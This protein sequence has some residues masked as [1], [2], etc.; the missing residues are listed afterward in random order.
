MASSP[1]RLPH[2]LDGVALFHDV[3]APMALVAGW[4][5]VFENGGAAGG[6]G[7]GLIQFS[8]NV[9]EKIAALSR[10]LRDGSYAPGPLRQVDIPKTNGGKRRLT[11]PPIV[12]RVAQS[13]A[14]QVLSPLLDREFEDASFGYRAG[15]SVADAVRRVE[16]LRRAG[17]VWTVD[18]DIDDFFDTIPIDRLVGR[19][20]RSVSEGPLVD[21]IA[22]WLEHGASMGRGIAQGSPLSPLLAN[23][24][25]DDLDEEFSGSGL[26]IV[27]YADDFLILAKSKPA[28]EAALTKAER[29][30]ATHGL[31]LDREKTRLRGY[32]DS[33]K[34]LGTTFVRGWA[35]R[36]EAEESGETPLEKLLRQVADAD[37]RESAALRVADDEAERARIGGFDRGL[38]ALH[39]GEAGRRLTLRNQSFAVHEAA[40]RLPPGRDA[41]LIAIHPSRID[42]IEIGPRTDVDLEAIRHALAFAI[43]LAFVN[44]HGE[45]L[46]QLATVLTPR[47]GRHMAQARAAIDPVARLDLARRIVE[48]RI[49]NQRALLRRL[50]H[51]R[52]VL[53]VDETAAKLGRILRKTASA[54]GVDG[55]MG[56]E[57]E[58][59]A[60]YWRAWGS[61]LLNGFSLGSR[62]RRKDADPINIA[63]DVLAGTLAR[64]IG[65]VL[66][67]VGLHPGFGVLHTSSDGRDA[68]VYDL[69]EEFRAGL[70][71]SVV[72]TAV[73]GARLS[74]NDFD[75]MPDGRYHLNRQGYAALIRAYEERAEHPITQPAS[76]RRMSWRRLMIEQAEAYVAHVEGRKPYQPFVLDH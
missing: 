38:R 45:T 32:D 27:R 76:G 70:V 28:A 72:L 43:P 53:G 60:L 24:Y 15:R 13:A 50:N 66:L 52:S 34:F 9:G 44:G 4:Q 31:K 1:K 21:L 58:A 8:I 55:L 12:D 46:G 19:L 49:A 41:E 48:G 5:R 57:G 17:F 59:T 64:D 35:M 39:V 23:L 54:T 10:S 69:M 56:I 2:P 26:R 20:A 6:D 7:V 11:I 74:L 22:R 65:A 42:R 51:R 14:A 18:A 40:D 37:A 47:A 71:E 3:T 67:R 63:L 33:L 36:L 29:L 61:L 16:E 73:N 68:C 25:L 62:L 30:L 75:Q